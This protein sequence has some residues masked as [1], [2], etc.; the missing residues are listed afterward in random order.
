MVDNIKKLSNKIVERDKEMNAKLE[1][2]NADNDR[3]R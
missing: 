2:T 1:K 3:K